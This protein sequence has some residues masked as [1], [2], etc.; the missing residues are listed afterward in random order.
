MPGYAKLQP[1]RLLFCKSCCVSNYYRISKKKKIKDHF[2]PS[3]QHFDPRANSTHVIHISPS[4]AAD[5]GM[6]TPFR[7]CCDGTVLLVVGWWWWWPR[8]VDEGVVIMEAM[9]WRCAEVINAVGLV[10]TDGVV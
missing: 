6:L 1:K 3:S 9:C 4:S 8:H 10:E 7:G 5:A 2:S